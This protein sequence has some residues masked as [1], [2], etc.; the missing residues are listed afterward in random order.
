[1]ATIYK[2]GRPQVFTAAQWR[3]LAKYYPKYPQAELHRRMRAKP[4]MPKITLSSLRGYLAVYHLRRHPTRNLGTWTKGHAPNNKG[5]KRPGWTS[6][7]SFKKGNKVYNECKVGTILVCHSHGSRGGTY[8]RIK[9]RRRRVRDGYPFSWVSLA[10]YNWEQHHHKRVPKGHVVRV[11]DGDYRNCA[12]ANLAMVSRKVNL[13]I[14]RW[15]RHLITSPETHL[16]VI[17]KAR[18]A[19]GIRAL[20]RSQ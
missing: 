15:Y 6:S 8:L 17:A 9:T 1:M 3:W 7:T 14:N 20:E 13:V 10:Q 12:P 16:A 4:G 5:V 2:Q 19:M 18:L 11:L